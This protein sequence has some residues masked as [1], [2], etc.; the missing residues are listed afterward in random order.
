M[1]I[2]ALEPWMSGIGGVGFMT[3]WSAKEGRAWTVDYGPVSAKKLDPSV[4]KIVG[5]GPANPFAWPDILEQSN[6]VGYHSIAV[7]GMVAGLA[8]A[9]ERF[10]TMKWKDVLQPGV[11]LAQR[12]MEL[13]WYMQVMIANGAAA[14]RRSSPPP[15]PTICATTAACRPTTGPAPSATSSS[16]ISARRCGAWP[17]AAR[18]NTTKAA[19]RATSPA[20]LQ[21][22]G[23]AI[24]YDDLASYEA[25]IVEPARLRA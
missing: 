15:R 10:G 17:K 11:E 2:G 13:D 7:P 18:A 20:D 25:R 22:G 9:L 24:S 16:A 14:P 5:P 8:K 1:A 4:Y 23:S 21:A 3:I 19:S 12:G 6:E